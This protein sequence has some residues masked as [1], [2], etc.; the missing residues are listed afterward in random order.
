MTKGLPAGSPDD[1]E[2]TVDTRLGLD[3]AVRERSPSPVAASWGRVIDASGDADR[4][5][6]LGA[7]SEVLVRFVNALVL[8]DYLRGAPQSGVEKRLQRLSRPSLGVL[9]GLFR[10]TCEALHTRGDVFWDEPVVAGCGIDAPAVRALDRLV[11]LR[12]HL[13]HQ[14]PSQAQRALLTAEFVDAGRAALAVMPWLFRARLLRVASVT[15]VSEGVRHGVL[16]SFM[17]SDATTGFQE[18]MRLESLDPHAVYLAH[19]S[20]ERLL[21][22]EPF[23]A[24]TD[25]DAQSPDRLHLW[26]HVRGLA[27]VT[28]VED[29]TGHVV[30]RRPRLD[31]VAIDFSVWALRRAERPSPIVSAHDLCQVL[32]AP[33]FDDAWLASLALDG[34]AS[35]TATSISFNA[36]TP[37]D[38]KES[39]PSLTASQ[40][41]RRWWRVTT[42]AAVAM[43]CLGAMVAS[44]IATRNLDAR[45][46]DGVVD[47]GEGCDDG[48][49]VDGDRCGSTCQSTLAAFPPAPLWLGYRDEEIAAGMPLVSPS[50]RPVAY[51]LARAAYAQPATP[52]LLGGYRLMKTEVSRGAFAV[53]L[54]D[55]GDGAVA[56]TGRTAESLAWHRLLMSRVRERR[57]H[58][59]A[60]TSP[61]QPLL[62]VE[63]PLD[64]AVAFCAWLGGA[65]PSEPQFEFAAKGEGPGRIFP[66][67]SRAPHRSPED[68]EL[69]TAHF[70]TS[71]DP[72][73]QVNCGDRRPTPIGSKPAGCT[74]EG[75]CDLSGNVDEWVHPGPVRWV[76][77]P[78]PNDATAHR[79]I[80]RLPGPR[81]ADSSSFDVA[82]TCAHIAWDDPYGLRTG[83]VRDCYH[84]GTRPET[85]T[86]HPSREILG[87]VRGGN[88]DDSLPV[89]YQTRA[90][91]PYYPL[92]FSKGFRCALPPDQD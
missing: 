34:A 29:G 42:A 81:A 23:V 60:L 72:P 62:P 7:F 48:N 77:E 45:C 73:T 50:R 5:I 46:G 25:V 43:T 54:K 36:L 49:V 17:G 92:T 35:L 87:V 40:N 20:G 85:P 67:G 86:T 82:M 74:P 65:L 37:L 78:D 14:H 44:G 21:D 16:Q 55:S 64:E 59:G 24:V 6:A 88:F 3:R 27:E 22:L 69:V 52:V 91:Y 68:C 61:T 90:R 15:A 19:P 58:D 41:N 53:F 26:K 4:L 30:H 75:I 28:L 11:E 10:E 80:A 39:M 31:G 18:A 79:W 84:P 13:V 57:R 2:G 66:W 83:N 8:P 47:P 70:M 56:H 12:N 63:V 38:T 89:F 33:T 1:V 32:R 51:L 71:L 9:C 76:L